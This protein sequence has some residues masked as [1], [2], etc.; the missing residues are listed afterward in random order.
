MSEVINQVP[1]MPSYREDARIP[2]LQ[3]QRQ[4]RG[5]VAQ[6]GGD[7]ALSAMESRLA[8]QLKSLADRQSQISLVF[9]VDQQTR[10][11][12]VFILDRTSRQVVRTIPAD[13]IAKLNPGDLIELFA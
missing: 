6:D 4:E 11:L 12:T 10:E 1:L 13:E 8:E 3:Y 5:P 9:K 7:D 2:A